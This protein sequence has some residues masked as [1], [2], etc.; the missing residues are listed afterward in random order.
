MGGDELRVEGTPPS[1]PER[2]Q[3]AKSRETYVALVRVALSVEQSSKTAVFVSAPGN[4]VAVY[5]VKSN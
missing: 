5:L 1:I 3:E 4:Q 2:A